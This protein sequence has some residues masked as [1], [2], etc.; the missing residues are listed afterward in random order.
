MRASR[1]E[2]ARTLQRI[3]TDQVLREHIIAAARERVSQVFDNKQL[4]QELVALY[5]DL[6]RL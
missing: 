4:I 2:F 5:R 3:V 1:I 6:T